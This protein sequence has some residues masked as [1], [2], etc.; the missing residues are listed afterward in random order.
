MEPWTFGVPRKILS[1]SQ[2]IFNNKN[3][4]LPFPSCSEMEAL[5]IFLPSLGFLRDSI[6]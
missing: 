3:K 2:D 1:L 6:P 4:E 5:F